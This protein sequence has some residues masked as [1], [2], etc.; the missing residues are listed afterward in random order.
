MN[1]QPILLG[2]LGD[3]QA[4]LTRQCMSLAQR[5]ASAVV[6]YE[7]LD[8][9][10]TNRHWLTHVVTV[11]TDRHFLGLESPGTFSNQVGGWQRKLDEFFVNV[12][13]AIVRGP[14]AAT[15]LKLERNLSGR[16]SM[17]WRE[18]DREIPQWLHQC[19]PNDNGSSTTASDDDS[20]NVANLTVILCRD[21]SLAD[22]YQQAIDGPTVWQRNPWPAQIGA[23]NVTCVW[24][25]SVAR[26]M[27]SQKWRDRLHSLLDAGWRRHVW[28]SASA[29][30]SQVASAR[31]AGVGSVVSCPFAVRGVISIP[32]NSKHLASCGQSLS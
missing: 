27:P 12:P 3:P 29:T 9:L 15:P 18:M 11:V 7:S 30:P 25:E 13:Q 5:H 19:D 21:A 31:Q 20:D 6:G 14:L 2:V 24:D 26:P 1:D 23:N 4:T 8:D 16:R 10:M 17:T 32:M 28:V 22:A